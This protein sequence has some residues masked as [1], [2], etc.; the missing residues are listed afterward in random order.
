MFRPLT[1]YIANIFVSLSI[2][3]SVELMRLIFK[4]LIFFLLIQ[5]E[6]MLCEKLLS[7]ALEMEAIHSNVSL[8]LIIAH[9]WTSM[10][11]YTNASLSLESKIN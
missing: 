1:M 5:M 4:K 10:H 8:N 11:E 9:D 3:L 7:E 6:K 2:S